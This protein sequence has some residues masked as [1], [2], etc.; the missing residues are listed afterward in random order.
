M[1]PNPVGL[2]PNWTRAALGDVCE[3]ISGFGFPESLQGR[4]E[5]DVPFYKVGDI[6]NAWKRG[7]VYLT[8]ANHYISRQQATSIT[9]RL[10]P[11]ATT[12]F[13]K[14]GAAIALNRRALL[15]TPALVDNNVMGLHPIDAILN[16]TYLFYFACTLRLDEISQA[17]TVPSI[18]KSDVIRIELPLAPLREQTRIVGEIEKQFTRLDSA[19]AALKPSRRRSP[20]HRD[21]SR[22]GGRQ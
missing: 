22:P 21:H 15:S 1:K 17:T 20:G 8:Q 9:P 5:G 18:R 19:V 11:A 10:L 16:A 13:A 3:I 7:S 4:T 6:S 2:P 14:I 12:V